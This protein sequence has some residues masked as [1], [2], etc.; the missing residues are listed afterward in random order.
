MPSSR[1]RP[2]RTFS[3]LASRLCARRCISPLL[4]GPPSAGSLASARL[5]GDSP[6]T[7]LATCERRLVGPTLLSNERRAP[8]AQ[9]T[10][11][12]SAA[13]QRRAAGRAAAHRALELATASCLRAPRA[14]AVARRRAAAR[15]GLAATFNVR[16]LGD[17][18]AGGGGARRNVARASNARSCMLGQRKSNLELARRELARVHRARAIFVGAACSRREIGNIRSASASSLAERAGLQ[19]GPQIA[20]SA[21]QLHLRRPSHEIALAKTARIKICRWRREAA[22]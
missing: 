14:T 18:R 5:A 6:A 3:R 20:N 4:A 19:L 8:S 9:R 10:L 7:D 2:R 22:L 16:W 1:R 17:R 13:S 12:P 11:Q 21:P 15:R